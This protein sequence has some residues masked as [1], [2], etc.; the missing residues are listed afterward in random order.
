MI[1]VFTNLGGQ[2]QTIKPTSYD[3]ISFQ[4]NYMPKLHFALFIFLSFSLELQAQKAHAKAFNY[5][6]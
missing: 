2:K 3:L 5:A 1:N 6:L 4:L